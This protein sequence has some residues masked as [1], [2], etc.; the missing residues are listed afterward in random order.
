[1]HW[2]EALFIKNKEGKINNEI[3]EALL[4]LPDIRDK[5]FF[6]RL[7]EVWIY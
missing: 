3:Y 2:K 7:Q 5:V 6:P 1:M 4:R